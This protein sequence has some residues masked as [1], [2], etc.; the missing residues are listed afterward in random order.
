MRGDAAIGGCAERESALKRPASAREDPDLGHPSAASCVAPHV[1][2]GVEGAGSLGRD[3]TL[4]HT[5][6]RPERRKPRRHVPR[7]VR[8]DGR[9]APV[10]P[11]C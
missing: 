9:P 7:P 1:E 10:M 3:G 8:V 6:E 2:D 11:L 4:P 5:R